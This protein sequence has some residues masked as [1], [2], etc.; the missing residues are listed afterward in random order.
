MFKKSLIAGVAVAVL[1]T[2]FLGRDA[3]SYVGT[4]IGW[5]KDSVKNSVPI[6]F[7]IERARR[8]IKNLVPDIRQNMQRIAA[9]EVEVERLARQIT[10]NSSRLARDR[11]EIMRLKTDLAGCSGSLKYA[12]R[13]YSPDE[14]KADLSHRFERY[15]THE[16]T[17][18]SLS[19]M[20]RARQR[21]LEAARQKLEGMLAMKRQLEVDVEHL[22]ARLKMVQTAQST[23]NYNFDDSQLSRARE[24]V[25]EVR[26]RLEVAERM[27][28][29]D[30]AVQSEIPLDAAAPTNIV[31]QVAD[32]FQAHDAEV[33]EAGN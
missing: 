24:L 27:V 16:A 14:V 2:F 32:Y 18:E 17:L 31:E 13:R 1:G 20:Q 25:T 30:V 26:T 28:E 3:L 10:D 7:E 11:D 12:G 33:A 29:V 19:Q 21:S 6:D 8:M 23:S 5:I 9:E 4:S 22:E 15:K